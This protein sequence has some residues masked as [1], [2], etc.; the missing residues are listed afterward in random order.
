MLLIDSKPFWREKPLS[1]NESEL[2]HLLF[3]AHDA[4]VYRP[5]ISSEMIVNAAIGSGDYG[6]AISAAILTL[7]SAH[8]PVSQVVSLLSAPV[9]HLIVREILR[10]GQKVPGWGS[11]FHPGEQDPL[12]V[13]VSESV[14]LNDSKLFEKIERCTQEFW[15]AGKRITQNPGCWTGAVAVILGMSPAVAPWLF[16]QGRLAGWTLLALNNL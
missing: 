15:S 8:A 3:K 6:K 10:N 12:W 11:S 9:P 7:G 1:D 5:N 2:L 16:I 13:G 4:S 14:R